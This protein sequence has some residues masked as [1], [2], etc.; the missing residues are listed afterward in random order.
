MFPILKPFQTH[1]GIISGQRR[2]SLMRRATMICLFLSILA[3]RTAGAQRSG[4]GARSSAPSVSHASV[5]DPLAPSRPPTL[6]GIRPGQHAE[7]EL[8]GELK[9]QTVVVQAPVVVTD[10]SGAHVHNLTKS[11]FQILEN[12]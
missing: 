5:P 11:D 7:D 2:S 3:S 1:R 4:G 12:G 8:K 9:S 6:S 10:K